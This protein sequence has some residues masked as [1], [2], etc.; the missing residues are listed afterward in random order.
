MISFNFPRRTIVK[1][2]DRNGQI[3]SANTY[4]LVHKNKNSHATYST[5]NR[6]TTEQGFRRRGRL[7]NTSLLTVM[8][9]SRRKPVS[10]SSMS[11]SSSTSSGTAVVVPTTSW[12]PPAE[13]PLALVLT[14]LRRF[15]TR[16]L[17]LLCDARE[18]LRLPASEARTEETLYQR[19]R[20]EKEEGG[21][22]KGHRPSIGEKYIYIYIKNKLPKT[23]KKTINRNNNKPIRMTGIY[24]HKPTT[25][26]TARYMISQTD[27]NEHNKMKWQVYDTTNRQQQNIFSTHINLA[28]NKKLRPATLNSNPAPLPL[29]IDPPP[30]S[31][32][33][34]PEHRHP[35][36]YRDHHFALPRPL[37]PPATVPQLPQPH[38]KPFPRATGRLLL[39]RNP[40]ASM[41]RRHIDSV[42][43]R[44]AG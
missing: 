14:R 33:A 12:S 18:A 25:M 37:P 42:R 27:N 20:E 28:S 19:P 23:I 5:K 38:P 22:R 24:Y 9:L 44:R 17:P 10:P 41:T 29:K 11:S 16:R 32:R 4:L 7:G 30:P 13:G 31:G 2:S 43:S 35:S 21:R 8:P 3:R 1:R 15:E 26:K 6:P 40:P 39:R 36:R 34:N